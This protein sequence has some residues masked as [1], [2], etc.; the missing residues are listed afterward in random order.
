MLMVSKE[1]SGITCTINTNTNCNLKCSYCYENNKSSNQ[2][3]DEKFWN[4][5]P[6]EKEARNYDFLM[7]Q[8]RN[9]NN[10]IDFDIAKKFI[11]LIL[12]SF[13][14]DSDNDLQLLERSPNLTKFIILDLIGGDSLQYPELV[15]KILDCWVKELHQRNHYY[16]F[17][18]KISISS[19]GVTLLNPKAREVCEKYKDSLSL[20]ISI[21]GCPKLHDLNRWCFADKEDGSHRGS[22]QYIKEIWPWYKKTFPSESLG[23][24]WTVTPHSY[25]FLFRSVKYLH[26]D[27]QMSHLFFNRVME[28]D[29]IDSPED[30]FECIHQFNE[31]TKYLI[32]HHYDLNIACFSYTLANPKSKT[33]LLKDDPT[34][35]R[36]GFGFMPAVALDGSIYPCF[37]LIHDQT[38]IDTHK[39]S[40]GSVNTS[41]I[42]NPNTLKNLQE[43]S[44]HCNLELPEE[45][46]VCN[47]YS[48]CPHCA[49]GCLLESSSVNFKKSLSVCNFHKISTY[50][51]RKYWEII[52]LKFPV[53][54][55]EYNIVWDREENEK[56]LE[57]LLVNIISSKKGE[58][59]YGTL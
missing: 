51:C 12:D 11:N 6:H 41:L 45:C 23:T 16:Q 27:L 28:K 58:L 18:Y 35:S 42:Y 52:T 26:E 39:Y 31:I 14:P 44:Q 57:Q 54:Y 43:K 49:A 33:V 24:K 25:K 9:K 40:Q 4:A 13:P 1:L 53:L 36:C 30:I 15:D 19:N 22:W 2:A 47:L 10:V 55:K 48:T 50:F 20:G 34:F 32:E 37:R 7:G 46:E 17:R 3:D 8:K 59:D 56:I 38:R 21:D 29:I 5:T